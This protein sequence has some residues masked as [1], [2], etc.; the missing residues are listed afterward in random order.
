MPVAKWI[1]RP[2]GKWKPSRPDLALR[3]DLYVPESFVPRP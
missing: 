1:W 2:P 3:K